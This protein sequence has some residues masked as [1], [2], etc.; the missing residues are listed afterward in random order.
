M[1]TMCSQTPRSAMSMISTE[2]VDS[3]EKA[4]LEA[5]ADFHLRICSRISL[6][7]VAAWAA[8]VVAVGPLVLV[9]ERMSPMD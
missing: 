8:V 5:W 9:V 1:P 6:V 3:P 2:R 7:E 4:V